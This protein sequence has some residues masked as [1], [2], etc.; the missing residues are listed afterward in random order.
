M[1]EQTLHSDAVNVDR[2]DDLRGGKKAKFPYVKFYPEDWMDGT[3]HLTLEQRGAYIA[4]LCLMYDTCEPIRDDDR[5]IAY[6]LMT[7]PRRWRSIRNALVADGKLVVVGDRLTNRRAEIEIENRVKLARKLR[8]TSVNRER[9]KRE[10]FEKENE[11]NKHTTTAVPQEQHYA[12]AT[13]DFRLQKE[14]I[15]S[16]LADTSSVAARG[17]GEISG[18]NGSTGLIVESMAHWLSPYAPDYPAAHTAIA[19]ACRIYGPKAVR[20]A[21]ADLKADH[22][23]GKV[24][25]LNHKAFYGYCRTAKDRSDKGSAPGKPSQADAIRRL[26][27]MA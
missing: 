2:I 4:F 5:W 22:L 18:L 17:P 24:R 9:K 8:E 15:S 6:Q 27:A 3:R 14:E 16:Q 10:N 25:A 11:I 12:R 7:T 20:D 19:E 21:F 1:T 26:E 13:S 23:D